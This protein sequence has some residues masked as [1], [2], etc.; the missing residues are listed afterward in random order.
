M[1]GS[2]RH[3]TN[4]DGTFAGTALLDHMG[5]AYEALEECHHMITVLSGGDVQLIAHAVASAQ[6]MCVYPVSLRKHRK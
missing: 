1:A 6:R 2:Y 3:I 4:D 5:D